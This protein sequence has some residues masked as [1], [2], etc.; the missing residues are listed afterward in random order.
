MSWPAP[1]RWTSL[2]RA[3]GSGDA[4]G[5]YD[6]L[7]GAHAEPQRHYD[8][9]Q[10]LVECLAELDEARH[11]ARQPPAVEFALWFHDAVY[12]PQATDN[13]KQSA[14]LARQCLAHI[15]AVDA[16]G[17]R[18]AHLVMTTK[19]HNPDGDADAGLLVDIDLSILGREPKRFFEYEQQ[20]RAEYAWVP[21][22]DYSA[23]RAEILERFLSRERIYTTEWFH[24]KYEAQARKNLAESGNQLRQK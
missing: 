20:I 8:T 21:A 14:R 24:Q 15:G 2:C 17:E 4:T 3:L 7:A 5:W 9:Q 16:L 19:F 11:L 6:R 13:E 10:H 12:F 18:V 22:A 23:K 1:E